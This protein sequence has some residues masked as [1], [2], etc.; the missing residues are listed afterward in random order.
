[1]NIRIYVVS[2]IIMLCVPFAL[3]SQQVDYSVVSV[4]EESGTEFTKITTV[5]DYVCMPVVNR[6]GSSINW[7]SKRILDISHE[8]TH[9]AYLSCRNNTVNIFIKDLSR[10]GGSVQRTNR[11]AIWD[12]SYSPDGKYL[13]FSEQRGNENQIFQTSSD[14]GY[15][16]RQMTSGNQ[17]F[18]PIYSS[19]MKLLLFAR[20]ERMGV[21][22]WSYNVGNNFLS[23]Y[24]SGMNPCPVPGEQAFLC[25]RTN[26]SGK[27]EIWK[28][29]YE[30][31]IETCIIADPDKNFTSPVL[32]PDGR[33]ILFVGESLLHGNGF[34]YPNTDLFVCRIDGTG[35]AQL[36][37]HAA[38]DLS[39]VWSKDGRFIYFISQRGSSD[40]TANIW[41]MNFNY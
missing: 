33:W 12:F 23:S 10:Q 28:I 17:D 19:D 3:F 22:I 37:Y 36:T 34:V 13:C 18:S 9:I 16:C 30:K 27:S 2:F 14:N 38:D 21:S 24:S 15:V 39:P 25:V 7:L 31:G 4:Q 26:A 11:T 1:M 6:S 29:D 5:G 20:Q 32:S 8:G 40:G 41:K 35:F